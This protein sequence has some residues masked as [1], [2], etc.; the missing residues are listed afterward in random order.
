MKL[1]DAQRAALQALST[2]D[3]TNAGDIGDVRTA[4]TLIASGFVRRYHGDQW[5]LTLRSDLA[6]TA[7]G[8]EALS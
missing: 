4:K 3:T 6:I 1:T 5:P 7:A 8:R 2:V